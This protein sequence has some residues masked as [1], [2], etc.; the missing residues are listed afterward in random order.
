MYM[1][2]LVAKEGN[3]GKFAHNRELFEMDEQ[4]VIRLNRDTLY[5]PAV[6]DL[7]AGPVTITLPDA[8]DR[9][10]SLMVVN[11]DHYVLDVHYAPGNYMYTR[12]E[13]GT[14]YIVAALRTLVDPGTEGDLDQVHAL[15]DAAQIHQP[16]GPGKLELPHWDLV[17]QKK[18]RDALLV[19]SECTDG[20]SGAFGRKEDVDPILHLIGTAAGWGGNPEKDAKYLGVLP[21]KNDGSTKYR[22]TVKDVPVEAFWSISVY[23]STGYFKK[24]DQ[25]A[26]TINNLTAKKEADG[27]VIIHFGGC[28]GT[29]SNCIPITEGWNY[30]VRLYR[31]RPEILDG[32]WKF[33]DLVEVD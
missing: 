29:A 21:A 32:S 16:G 2:N 17:S 23:D 7:D 5:S 10:M 1:S 9:F 18:I 20:F 33:P 13:A 8:G 28:D 25:N 22:L 14:R 6:I 26:Y 15:Q 3:L 24:N 11:E 19:L 27:S 30:T 12:E 4:V 31:P